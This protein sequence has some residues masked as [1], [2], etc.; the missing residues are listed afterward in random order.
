MITPID[1]FSEIHNH[2][3]QG[4]MFHDETASL[5]DFMGLR[6]Y[7]RCHEYQ[8]LKE[9]AAAR[10]VS[11]YAVNHLNKMISESNPTV[12]RI[13]P[14]SWKAATRLDVGES[15]RKTMIK[16]LF[17]KWRD[18][19]TQTKMFYCKKFKEL[20]D[21]GY[22]ACANKV[23]ELICDVDCELKSLEREYIA[24]SAVG[25]DM[26]YIMQKQDEVHEHY[27]EKEKKIGV[28]FN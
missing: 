8:A 22:I 11:R 2:Q 17:K 6:G 24:L 14:S 13:T 10:G 28:E 18:W 21:N 19:E 25:F 4:V 16:D 7:K 1:V 15:D 3:I 26:L 9:F 5:Y 12:T 23:N 27:E 20:T